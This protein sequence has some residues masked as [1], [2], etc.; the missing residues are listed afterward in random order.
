MRK[1]FF[2]LGL[3]LLMPSFA[4]AQI[5]PADTGLTATGDAVFGPLGNNASIGTFIGAR[6]INPLFALTGVA[7]L[8]LMIYGGFLWM[9]AGGDEGKVEEATAI[10]RN[11][12]IGLVI[13]LSAYAITRF[14]IIAVTGGNSVI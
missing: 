7:F 6:V 4:F 5:T 3:F 10:F 2:L 8:L 13:I 11:A 9:T 14:V 12:T 1:A